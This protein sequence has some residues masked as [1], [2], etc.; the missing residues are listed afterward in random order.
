MN[1]GERNELLFKIYL[2]QLKYTKEVTNLFGEIKNCGFGNIEYLPLAEEINLK[3]I[4]DKEIKLLAKKLN[5]KKSPPRAKA[6][7]KV[8][9]LYISIKS[10]NAAPPS[11]INHTSR[12]GF[13][14]IAEFLNL[15][16]KNLDRQIENYWKLRIFGSI[17]EDCSNDN[18]L[19]PFK[20]HKDIWRPYLEYFCFNGTG[21]GDSKF[22][23]DLLLSIDTFDDKASWELIKKEEA[24]DKI[25]SGLKFCIRGGKGMDK[26]QNPKFKKI[27]SPWTE[28]SSEKYRGALTVR[29]KP[30]KLNRIV[31]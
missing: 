21:D 8:N 5:I 9:D 4:N 7:I 14:R 24:I 29:Y 22:P 15:D 3:T 18:S 19:S 26:Y 11:I 31:L 27:M 17:S 16:I 30:L 25:W 1:H 28:F 13:L 12:L 23:A 2:C 20:N 6:D 10:L